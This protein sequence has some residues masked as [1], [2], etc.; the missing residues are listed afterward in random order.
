MRSLP[1]QGLGYGL[2]RYL[3][4]R[5]AGELAALPA[6]QLWFNYLGRFGFDGQ[7]DWSG[8]SEGEGLAADEPGCRWRI[9]WVNALTL[10][11]AG[12]PQLVANWSGRA[13]A[14]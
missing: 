4:A 6:P 14:A 10:D 11:G 3:N 5:T 13:V 9:A 8:A 12:G 1:R 2:L 7:A